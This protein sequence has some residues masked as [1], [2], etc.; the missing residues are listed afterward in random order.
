MNGEYVN[1]PVFVSR[2]ILNQ[3]VNQ[4]PFLIF[5]PLQAATSSA[6]MLSHRSTLALPRLCIAGR[7]QKRR[8]RTRAACALAVLGG[9]PPR[10]A[11]A[12]RLRMPGVAV[13]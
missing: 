12:R 3:C 1:C 8:V 5:C 9:S 4:C 7:R 6:R 11:A 10:R 13:W 2:E